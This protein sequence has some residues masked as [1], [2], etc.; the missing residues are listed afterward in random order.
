[1]THKEPPRRPPAAPT[2]GRA[3]RQQWRRRRRAKG[4]G[5]GSRVEAVRVPLP[6]PSLPLESGRTRL[7]QAEPGRRLAGHPQVGRAE[8]NGPLAGRRARPSRPD[9]AKSSPC[10]LYNFT[11]RPPNFKYIYMF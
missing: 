11:K 5:G 1:M 6:H 3:R 4:G 9:V 7:A 8:P 2:G 10:S